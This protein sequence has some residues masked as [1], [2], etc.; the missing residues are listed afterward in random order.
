[1]SSE[2]KSSKTERI[3]WTGDAAAAARAITEHFKREGWSSGWYIGADYYGIRA[4]DA[5]GGRDIQVRVRLPV[6]KG[7]QGLLRP[8]RDC[9]IRLRVTAPEE[10]VDALLSTLRQLLA[11]VR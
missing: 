1:M 4:L 2:A 10:S 9:H 7:L 11:G 3:R 8:S 5:E 6:N